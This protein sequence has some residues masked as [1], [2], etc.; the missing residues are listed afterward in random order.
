MHSDLQTH[1]MQA[2]VATHLERHIDVAPA[3]P[4]RETT[5]EPV[6]VLRRATPG[7]AG[8]LERL[9]QLDS[10][11][12]LGDD[13]LIALVDDE[14]IAALALTDRR[15]A[16]DPFRPSENAVKLLRMRA[17]HLTEE[18]PARHPRRRQI[19]HALRG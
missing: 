10:V 5:T 19:L 8:A 1:L 17:R 15:A 9:A 16:A 11:A 13:V 18:R 4:A 3:D 14:P 12:P 2:N 6:L 7:D